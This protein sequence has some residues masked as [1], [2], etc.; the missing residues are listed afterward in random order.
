MLTET[1]ERQLREHP[2]LRELAEDH[3]RL[4]AGCA[5]NARFA[6]GARI[7][8]EGDEETTFYLLRQGSVAL[9]AHAPGRPAA[10]VETLVPGDVLGVSWL[11]PGSTVH[12]DARAR[13]AV[14]AFALDG[15]CLREKME[16][17]DRLAAAIT[18][19]LLER[20]Y[21]RLARLRLLK[22]DIYR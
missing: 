16:R 3:L 1:L 2:F 19:R 21:Q 15:G 4:L 7:L 20:T 11:F 18:R 22:L 14:V 9:E 5:K 13:E 12:L 17:D 10:C 8:R 6:A